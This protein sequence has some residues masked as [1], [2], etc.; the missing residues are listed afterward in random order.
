MLGLLPS[1]LGYHLLPS[2]PGAPLRPVSAPASSSAAPRVCM[3]VVATPSSLSLPTPRK[4]SGPMGN[5]AFT[6]VRKRDAAVNDE[7]MRWYLSSIGTKRLLDKA[8]EV[9]L[10]M[11]VKELLA[12]DREGDRLEDELGRRPTRREWA[13]ALGFSG[14]DESLVRFESQARAA[15]A[16]SRPRLDA[17][18]SAIA[19]QSASHLFF[20]AP[21]SPA[22]P[23]TRVRSCSPVRSCGSSGMQR[24]G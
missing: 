14:T 13:V 19:P 7:T 18:D 9:K 23:L 22:A 5:V 1:F 10:A 21:H 12:W 6:G 24:S 8:E 11:A 15:A 3:Q 20:R 16:T 2:A 17:A 4:A